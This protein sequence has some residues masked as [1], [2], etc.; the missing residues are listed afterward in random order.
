[1]SSVGLCSGESYTECHVFFCALVS[2]KLSVKCLCSGVS[3]PEWQGLVCVLVSLELCVKGGVYLCYCV[4]YTECLGLVQW[5]CVTYTEYHGLVCVH[6]LIH[7][8]SR[9]GLCYRVSHAG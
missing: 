4:S 2:P 9:F 8:M 1:M 5:S 6:V 7:Y 3:R